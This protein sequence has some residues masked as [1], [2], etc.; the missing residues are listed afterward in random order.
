MILSWLQV[1]SSDVPI[2]TPLNTLKEKPL[3]ISRASCC[4]ALSFWYCLANS[5]CFG[6][7][8]LSELSPQLKKTTGLCYNPETLLKQYASA[9]TGLVL[10]ISHFLGIT[11][12]CCPMSHFFKTIVSNIL[13]VFSDASSRRVNPGPIIPSIPEE[14]LSI[15]FNYYFYFKIV[16]CHKDT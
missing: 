8:N 4:L 6:L 3:Q 16:K 10:F 1:V 7:H 9:I 15:C 12:F 2:I 11:L 14:V 5:S 13:S